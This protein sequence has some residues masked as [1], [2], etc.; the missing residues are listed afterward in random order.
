MRQTGLWR[1]VPGLCALAVIIPMEGASQSKPLT[2]EDMMY[3]RSIEQPVMSRDGR[4]VAYGLKPDRGDGEAVIRSTESSK[5]FRVAR[6]T[7]PQ[8][9]ND[10][11]WVAVRVK[12]S[13]EAI[14]K[15]G[16]DAS[17]LHDTLA[18]VATDGRIMTS[19]VGDMTSFHIT[20]DSRWIL[21]HRA[22]EESKEKSKAPKDSAAP[23]LKKG[24]GSELLVRHLPSAAHFWQIPFVKSFSV[25]TLSRFLVYAVE[26]ST[27]SGNGLYVRRLGERADSGR[28]ILQGANLR[29]SEL[30]W[31]NQTGFLAFVACELNQKEEPKPGA[32]WTW[33]PDQ[34]T[35]RSIDPIP[36]G[37]IVPS[38]NTLS[39]SRDGDRLYLGLRPAT[40]TLAAVS[41]EDT[42]IHLFDVTSILD[43]RAVDIWHWNDPLINPHQKKQWKAKSEQTYRAVYHHQE[44]SLVQLADTV[45]DAVTVTES[46]LFALGR[47]DLAYQ[48]DITWDGSYADYAVVNQK[49]GERRTFLRRQS[50]R[51]RTSPDGLF[52]V[53]FRDSSWYLYSVSGDSTW[54]VSG[55]L[56]TPFYNEEDDTPSLPGSYGSPGWMTDG[57]AVLVYDRFDIWAIPTDGGAPRN[58][59]KGEGRKRSLRLRVVTLDPEFVGFAD[60]DVLLLSAYSETEKT[61]GVYSLSL[62]SQELKALASGVRRHRLVAKALEADRVLFTRESYREF[63]NLWVATT[64]LAKPRQVSDAN[65]QMKEFAWGQAEL[66]R[67]TSLDGVPLEGVL[68]T[69]ESPKPEKGYPVIVY[70]YERM[71]QR[72]HEFNEVVINHRPCFPFYASNGYAVFLPDVR[73]QTGQPGFSATKCV[74]PGV[75]KLVDMGVADPGAIGLHG[76]SWG[77]YETAFIVTQTDL[78]A[79]AIAGA[80]VGNMT[81]A[82]SG[83]RWGSGMARQFQY[84][85]SQSRIGGS[86]WEYPERFIENSPVFFA[87]RVTTP[88]L[89]MH[90]DD[91][92]AVPWYQS[93]ELYLALRRFGKDCIFLQYR[94][95][96]HHPR[97]YANKLDYAIRMKEYFDHYLKGAAPARWITDGIP[98]NGK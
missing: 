7:Q 8:I 13:A 17:K 76:H 21:I 96:P 89:L 47:T 33:D 9:S 83:I 63:P 45:W 42:T 67:W 5:E 88:L 34:G 86:L 72:L 53:F 87:D 64:S 23:K 85:K 22:K 81:S 27:G 36:T 59:T 80:P 14:E 4:W 24:A 54:N 95:E 38:K 82:Y 10:G 37:W 2:F 84:E 29:I 56:D 60:S 91:D 25:D 92:D 30:T 12:P 19:F 62:A 52:A 6:G 69:P 61:E 75:Q 90:G 66:V 32:V 28:P 51:V 3:F 15:A 11:R 18:I 40:D 98:Y 70:F 39:W 94:N 41:D 35:A 16:K 58:L 79:A 74:V 48:K 44:Q 46:P 50:E 26:D 1:I 77:G 31:N 43:K 68:I 20:E 71:S 55:G 57:S 97:T 49:T 78:F 73:Y 65:P 93:I